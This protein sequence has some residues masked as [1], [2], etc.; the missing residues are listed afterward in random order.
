MLHININQ[1]Q[2]N[3]SIILTNTLTF[4]ET[5]FNNIDNLN[6]QGY[7]DITNFA[8]LKNSILNY[9]HIL[10]RTL[11]MVY[12]ETLEEE[13]LLRVKKVKVLVDNLIKESYL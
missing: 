9:N 2:I 4:I 5:A 8:M 3:T 12:L 1:V 13:T 11:E 6:R 10:T 7:E